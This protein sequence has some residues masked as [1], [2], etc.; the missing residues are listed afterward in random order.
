MRYSQG[1][2][3]SI[4]VPYTDI[5]LLSMY[6]AGRYKGALLEVKSCQQLQQGNN[7][8]SQQCD[9]INYTP[10]VGQ[11]I[12]QPL[13]PSRSASFWNCFVCWRDAL[14][15]TTMVC[16]SIGPGFDFQHLKVVCN[17][18]PRGFDTQ[19]GHCRQCLQDAQTCMQVKHPYP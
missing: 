7:A 13:Y 6:K 10:S 14:A 17:S 2:D 11:D 15:L 16:S 8:L 19:S 3:Y 12:T 18:T 1:F 5:Q 4:N 9:S